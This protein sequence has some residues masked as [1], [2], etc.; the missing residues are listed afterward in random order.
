[1]PGP[2]SRTQTD[3][4]VGLRVGLDDDLDRGALPAVLG[5]VREQVADD[6]L[7]V[8]RVGHHGR[9]TGLD[10]D[11]E[12]D[13]RPALLLR[14]DDRRHDPLEKDRFPAQVGVGLAEPT[15]R[16][17][18]LDQAFEP[19]GLVGDVGEDLAAGGLVEVRCPR[20]TGRARRRRS[21]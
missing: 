14:G 2:S 11:R 16:D 12:R 7:E 6:L 15:Q 3:D 10:L 8:R 9:Q 5:G 13:T 1:M 19:L 21:S 18:V 17:D 20:G 4:L